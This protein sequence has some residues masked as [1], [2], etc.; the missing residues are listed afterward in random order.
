MAI[1][2]SFQVTNL[3]GLT[4]TAAATLNG[5]YAGLL[6]SSNGSSYFFWYFP[7]PNVAANNSLVI[8]LNGGPGCSS[9]EGLF[10]ELGP[11]QFSDSGALQANPYSW[12][13]QANMLFIEQP[14]GVGFNPNG[15]DATYDEIGLAGYFNTFLNNWF[16]VFPDAKSKDLYITGESYAG[17]YIPYIATNLIQAKTFKDGSPIKLKGLGIG[18]PALGSTGT[19]VDYF[20][21]FRD[22]GFLEKFPADFV[23]QVGNLTNQCQAGTASN[24]TD[25]YIFDTF[26]NQYALDPA[27][28]TFGVNNTCPDPY[29]ITKEYP[30]DNSFN[31]AGF[32]KEGYMSNFLNTPSVQAAVHVTGA[33]INWNECNYVNL[34]DSQNAPSNTLL[35][36]IISAGVNVVIYD[37][38]QDSVCSYVA[39]ERVLGNTT[40]AGAE[41]FSTPAQNWVVNGKNSGLLWNDRNLTY[42]RLFGPGHMVPGDDP[43]LGS[44]VLA[45][46]LFGS[47]KPALNLAVNNGIVSV[48]T[49]ASSSATSTATSPATSAATSSATSA[50]ASVATTSYV[51][52]SAS[53]APASSYVPPASPAASYNPAPSV[54]ATTYAPPQPNNL[55]KSGSTAMSVSAALAA[56][57]V[58]LL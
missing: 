28:T 37:G 36:G 52:P 55:Y 34:T 48:V 25:C 47:S 43:I 19:P 18:N 50:A 29:W 44:A 8:W 13:L 27:H 20:D 26:A 38:D 7:T 2:A 57:L 51:A 33:H 45:E 35:D 39:V 31:D 23:A 16:N 5:Q 54:A 49:S 21:F 32:V 40:W 53:V 42:V 11:L 41:G 10:T 46:A 12:H 14:A 58:M 1:A 24:T 6:P 15:T 17:T 30:C 22:S 9:L 4:A 3:P 56:G